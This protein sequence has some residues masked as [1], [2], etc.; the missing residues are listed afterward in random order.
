[1]MGDGRPSS[2]RCSDTD[3]DSGSEKGSSNLTLC[4]NANGCG[5]SMRHTLDPF[6]IQKMESSSRSTLSIESAVIFTAKTAGPMD[7]S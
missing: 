7:A 2:S 5:F 4:E 6:P 1:M 3:S